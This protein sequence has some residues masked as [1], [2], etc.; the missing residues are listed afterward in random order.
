MALS[1]LKLEVPFSWTIK[2]DLISLTYPRASEGCPQWQVE[3]ALPWP[4]LS[5]PVLS[6]KSYREPRTHHV[7]FLSR[8][9]RPDREPRV[10]RAQSSP[11]LESIRHCA[12]YK[13]LLFYPSFQKVLDECQNQRAC[14][15]LVNSR[16]FGP[17]LCPGSS[18]YLL[19]SFKCQPS[20]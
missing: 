4:W 10:L 6:S 18:K 15:L 19:V 17:D 14:H 2:G 5:G 9:L 3:S 13:P 7:G 16:V 12:V 20:K 11:G 1:V 8:Q